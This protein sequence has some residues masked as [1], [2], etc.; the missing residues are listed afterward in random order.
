MHMPVNFKLRAIAR[1]RERERE[2]ESS[3]PDA[4]STM[5]CDTGKERIYY[6]F[7]ILY[8]SHYYAYNINVDGIFVLYFLSTLASDS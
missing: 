2:R 8:S 4:L 5:N 3:R 6:R 1:E 7:H